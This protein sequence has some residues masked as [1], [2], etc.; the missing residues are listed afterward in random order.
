MVAQHAPQIRVESVRQSRIETETSPSQVISDTRS[1]T[2]AGTPLFLSFFP[3]LPRGTHDIFAGLLG[4]EAKNSVTLR[5]RLQALKNAVPV[6]KRFKAFCACAGILMLGYW[7]IWL[8][9][10]GCLIIVAPLVQMF[11]HNRNARNAVES[12]DQLLTGKRVVSSPAREPLMEGNNV[13][14][15]PQPKGAS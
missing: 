15:P 3:P 12:V 13:H 7:S 11:Q 5:T 9:T 10:I 1:T 8:A 2:G 4:M 14:H 6:E